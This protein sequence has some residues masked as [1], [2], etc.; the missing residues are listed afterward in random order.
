MLEVSALVSPWRKIGLAITQ[1]L[2]NLYVTFLRFLCFSIEKSSHLKRAFQIQLETDLSLFGNKLKWDFRKNTSQ[3]TDIQHL[4]LWAKP[5]MISV[6]E[7]D[8]QKECTHILVWM[9]YEKD[10]HFSLKTLNEE[11]INWI[12]PKIEEEKHYIHCLFYKSGTH[13]AC[14]ITINAIDISFVQWWNCP[15]F[16]QGTHPAPKCVNEEKGQDTWSDCFS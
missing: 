6:D 14:Q 9:K 8:C 4:K 10:W 15:F 11:I 2:K 7:W 13:R 12:R 1:L 5:T 16:S 3:L